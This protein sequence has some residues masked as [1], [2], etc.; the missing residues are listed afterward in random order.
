M[1]AR[2][3]DFCARNRLLVLVGVLFG[4]AGSVWALGHL[5]L[6]AIPDLS[7]PQVIVFTA[8]PGAG[9]QEVESLAAHA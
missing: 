1:V 7:D 5:Q 2:V 9:P 3:V 4:L 8:W 6:D